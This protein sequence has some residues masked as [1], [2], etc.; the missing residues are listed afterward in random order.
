MKKIGALLLSIALCLGIF[1]A[2]VLAQEGESTGDTR[3]SESTSTSDSTGTETTPTETEPTEPTGPTELK[4]F[5]IQISVTSFGYV[6]VLVEDEDDNV[7]TG[8][9]LHLE[10]DGEE[11]ETK[12]VGSSGYLTFDYALEAG[13]QRIRVFS[14]EELGYRAASE[15]YTRNVSPEDQLGFVFREENRRFD[16]D[17]G[18][19]VM[20]WNYYANG[21][22]DKFWDIT[23]IVVDGERYQ[24]ERGMGRVRANILNLPHG[25]HTLSYVFSATGMEN[26]TLEA[27]PL[28]RTGTVK[29]ILSLSEENNQITATVIDAWDRPVP[30]VPVTLTVGSTVYAPQKTD[31]NGTIVF[32]AAIPAGGT[33]Y[34]ETA[35]ITTEDGVTYEKATATLQTGGE[36]TT[37]TTSTTRPSALTTASRTTNKRTTTSQKGETTTTAKTYPTVKGAGTT[38]YEDNMVVMNTTFDTGVVDAFGLKNDDFVG[39]ARLLMDKEDYAEFVGDSNAVVMLSARYSPLTV[40]DDQISTAISNQ[41]KFSRYHAEN[42]LRVTFDLGIVFASDGTEMLMSSVPDA[43]YTVQLPVPEEMK[44]VKLIAV[45]TTD[46]NGIATPV[47]V[48]VEDGYLRFDTRFLSTFTLLGFTEA[49]FSSGGKTP[50]IVIVVFV[51][52]GLLLVGAGLLFYFFVL[53]KPAEEDDE[54]P[55][56]EGGDD[57]GDDPGPGPDSPPPPPVQPGDG[58]LED[59]YSGEPP[60]M[61]VP[62]SQPYMEDIYSSDDRRPH[63]RAGGGRGV[64]LGSLQNGQP[65]HRP[66][67]QD[68]QAR[69]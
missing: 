37:G 42:V 27:E 31:R 51:I 47:E 39:K 59:I 67:G 65:L 45:A 28:V 63:T 33:V 18:E 5:T 12:E 13:D 10:V 61:I 7:P 22:N 8:V 41:S 20:D 3:S 48:I 56:P 15:V 54:T 43:A 35:E 29:T 30:D 17:T 26:V 69:E 24:V 2:A 62:P 55:P 19:F 6:E 32:Y 38:A 25:S 1:P 40:S 11:V 34:A 14:E 50:T 53:R 58:T 64:S 60:V 68:P 36:I 4:E 57:G 49:R 23:A 21:L 16:G 44:D 46:E 66:A 52:A 9:R